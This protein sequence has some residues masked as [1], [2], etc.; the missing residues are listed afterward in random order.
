LSLFDEVSKREI[1]QFEK[2]DDN[3]L[4]NSVEDLPGEE[5]YL[6]IYQSILQI[7]KTRLV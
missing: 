3:V 5:V 7:L 6:M 2:D 4:E 1:I